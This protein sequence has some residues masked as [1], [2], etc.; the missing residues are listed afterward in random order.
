MTACVQ[1]AMKCLTNLMRR[2]MKTTNSINK[3]MH[4]NVILTFNTQDKN[5]LTQEFFNLSIPVSKK[6]VS[7]ADF[8]H[9]KFFKRV[10]KFFFSSKRIKI[11]LFKRF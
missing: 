4:V 1:R 2:F 8:M 11:S 9:I 7:A 10:N 6:E 5:G 3:H